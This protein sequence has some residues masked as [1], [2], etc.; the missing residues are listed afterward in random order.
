MTFFNVKVHRASC[1][2]EFIER[3]GDLLVVGGLQQ[4]IHQRHDLCRRRAYH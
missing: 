2:P 4:L 3:G 1:E